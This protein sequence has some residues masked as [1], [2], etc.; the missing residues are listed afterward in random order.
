MDKKTLE[1]ATQYTNPEYFDNI[2]LEQVSIWEIR[3]VMSYNFELVLDAN[4]AMLVDKIVTNLIANTAFSW[5]AKD[6]S[7]VGEAKIQ[8]LLRDNGRDLKCFNLNEFPT[9]IDAL[10][11]KIEKHTTAEAIK[12]RANKIKQKLQQKFYKFRIWLPMNLYLAYGL[13]A[14]FSTVY[15]IWTAPQLLIYAAITAWVFCNCSAILIHEWWTHDLVIPRNRLISFV[16][17]YLGHILFTTS[18]LGWR[19]EHRWHHKYWKTEKDL[20]YMFN[21]T[22]AWFYLFFSTSIEVLKGIE[23]P[24]RP[25][26][27]TT[28]MVECH[29]RNMAILTPE[30]RFLENHWVS[31]SVISHVI[32]IA[33]MGYVNWT[34]FVLLQAWLFRCYIIGFNEITTHWPLKLT[35]EQET[36]TP[37]L[38][39]LCCGTAYHVDHHFNAT[40][41][42]LGPG[43]LKYLNIQYWFIRLFFKPAPGAKYS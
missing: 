18:R 16:F 5:T 28:G 11:Q 31:I 43:K 14:I 30:S 19:W 21:N 36:N 4:E 25:A 32:L 42:V 15:A 3:D 41:I 6:L 23:P 40:Q 7:I 37:Y 10:S 39:P 8:S 33:V 27:Y 29:E 26:E 13:L 2:P 12:V 9:S 38:F 34:Y 24:K 22:P 17:D 35:R 1:L 20:D